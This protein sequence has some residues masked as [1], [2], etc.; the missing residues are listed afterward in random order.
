MSNI[1]NEVVSITFDNDGFEKGVGEVLTSLD[2]LRESIDNQNYGEAFAGIEEAAN[3][4]D[5]SGIDSAINSIDSK[6]SALGAVAFTAIQQVTSSAVD[7]ARSMFDRTLGQIISGG[8]ARYLAIEQARFRFQGLGQDVEASMQ[9]AL[10]AVRGTAYGLDE[11]ATLAAAFGGAGTLMGQDLTEALRGVAGVSSVFGQN[12]AEIGSIFQ[13]V[14]AKGTLTGAHL[15]S[16]TSRGIGMAQ[17]LGRAWGMSVQEV[18]EAAS[19]GEITFERFAATVYDLFGDQ[20][21][22]ANETYS[23]SLDNLHAAMNRVGEALLGPRLE[24]TRNV[25]NALA[26]KIDEVKEALL[27]LVELWKVFVNI[28]AIKTINFL[29]SINVRT[30]EKLV[31]TIKRIFTNLYSAIGSFLRPIK[32]AFREIFPAASYRDL[33]KV[34][35]AIRRFTKS[36]ELSSSTANKVKRIFAGVFAVVRIGWEVFKGIV[37]VIMDVVRALMPVG[38]GFLSAGASIGDFLVYLKEVLVDGRGI[39]D[40]FD[41]VGKKLAEF[42]TAFRN[43]Q[44]ISAFGDAISS[45][46]DAIADLFGAGRDGAQGL[47]GDL[48][49]VGQRFDQFLGILTAAAGA[50]GAAFSGIVDFL[51]PALDWLLD[52]FGSLG[53]KIAEAM[54]DGDFNAV[55]DIINTGLFG[56]IVGLFWKFLRDG[57]TIDLT[58]GTMT[59]ITESFEAL[60]GTLEAMQL[61]LKAGALEKIAK[62]VAILTVSIV[63]LSLI[64]SAALTKALAAIAVGFTELGAVMYGFSKLGLSSIGGVP[65]LIGLASAMVIIAGSMILMSIAAFLFSRLDTDELIRGLAGLGTSLLGLAVVAKSMA[66]TA[67]EL[68]VTG[69]AILAIAGAVFILGLATAI[70]AK[71]QWDTLLRGLFGVA[72][73]LTGLT[74]AMRFIPA[75]AGAKAPSLLALGF[76]LIAISKAVEKMGDLEWD[77]IAKGLIGLGAALGGIVL[78]ANEMTGSVA[79]AFAIGIISLALIGLAYALKQ[80]GEMSWGQMISGLLGMAAALIIVGGL[81]VILGALSEFLILGALALIPM[82]FA[83][84]LLANVVEHFG[85]I[86]FG[87]FFKA[88]LFMALGLV[89]VAAASVL[90][91]PAAP[92]IALFGA[93]LLVFGAGLAL[94]GAGIYL[95]AKGIETFAAI[96][97]E[98]I[99]SLREVLMTLIRLIPDL[100]TELAEGL[101]AFLMVLVDHTPELV[102]G[103]QAILSSLFTAITELAPQWGEA[104]MALIRSGLDVIVSMAPELFQ[105]GF[106]LLLDFLRGVAENIPAICAAAANIVRALL[107][108]IIEYAPSV[109]TAGPI[110]MFKLITGILSRVGAIVGAAATVIGRFIGAVVSGAA[111]LIASG[112]TAVFNFMSGIGS[113]IGELLG[114][115]RDVVQRFIEGLRNKAGELLSSGLSAVGSFIS[116]IAIAAA[117][118]FSKGLEIAGNLISGIVSG[119]GAGVGRVLD[120]IGGLVSDTVGAITSGFGIFSPSRVFRDVGGRLI[121]GLA[122]GIDDHARVLRSTDAMTDNVISHMANSAKRMTDMFNDVADISPTITPV[123][124]LTTVQGQAGGISS[125]LSSSPISADLSYAQARTVAVAAQEAN[126]GSSTTTDETPRQLIFEQTINANTPLSPGEIY[127]QTRSQISLAKSELEVA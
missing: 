93:A 68:I 87:E 13:D 64:D 18:E 7:A 22:R 36:L 119:I 91:L 38:G 55:L 122:L 126:E 42:I 3:N 12:F 44:F 109:F 61:Q 90:L 51:Q 25:F 9:S 33:Q 5:I 63:A 39:A 52:T 6:F 104:L 113:R 60:T 29:D 28:Q 127:R 11:A 24:A 117:G 74:L 108:C 86:G 97:S 57:A 48:G 1:E 111:G 98:G 45:A 15:F 62:A 27:P 46:A 82:V 8:Q 118:L 75:D 40:F 20:A 123:L 107:G 69:G 58:G 77:Q 34:A 112:A 116:G 14:A 100:A 120:A 80:F 78:V 106:T 67:P 65:G 32:E 54:G 70:F 43:S 10:E 83:L 30:L 92:A 94:V 59:A 103:L 53:S 79:G 37:G 121:D 35:G 49:R 72:T 73:G 23:G 56:G 4:I 110:L 50:I 21:T 41:A 88:L 102:E 2:S 115:G 89:A 81:G 101:I 124:D 99:A 16:F 105:A 71:M 114:K 19:N 66:R 31:P 85:Q 95:A 84:G 125:L 76:S 47:D 96:S 26:P 17:Q